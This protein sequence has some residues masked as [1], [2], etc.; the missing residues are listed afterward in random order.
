MEEEF[1]HAVNVL[2]LTKNKFDPRKIR[3]GKVERYKFK[4]I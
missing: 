1:G 4:I 2:G 3:N